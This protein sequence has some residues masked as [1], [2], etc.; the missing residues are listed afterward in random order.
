MVIPKVIPKDFILSKKF[1]DKGAIQMIL[2]WFKEFL[3]SQKTILVNSFFF[4][5]WLLFGAFVMGLMLLKGDYVALR[6]GGAY[7]IWPHFWQM[8]CCYFFIGLSWLGWRFNHYQVQK[9]VTEKH[10]Q[11]NNQSEKS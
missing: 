8:T 5:C 4:L 10:I 3:S 11:S 1:S 6:N 7:S 2:M 9:I